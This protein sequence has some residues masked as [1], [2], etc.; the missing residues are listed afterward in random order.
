MYTSEREEGLTLAVSS[1]TM[2]LAISTILPTVVLLHI[3]P[4]KQTEGTNEREDVSRRED[5]GGA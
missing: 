4:E 1:E 3:H 5:Q 2:E